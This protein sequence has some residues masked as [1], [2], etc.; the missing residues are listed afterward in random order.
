MPNLLW[1]YIL[2]HNP[3]TFPRGRCPFRTTSEPRRWVLEYHKIPDRNPPVFDYHFVAH[4]H[5]PFLGLSLRLPLLFAVWCEIA[6]R[7]RNC[8]FVKECLDQG[9]YWAK[10]PGHGV[11][12]GCSV[13][14]YGGCEEL[15][16]VF[17]LR[18]GN[19]AFSRSMLELR[20]PSPSVCSLPM[21]WLSRSSDALS[22]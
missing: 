14:E 21:Q 20:V 16:P 8:G 19:Y 7:E 15:R 3:S 13:E 17:L 11:V 4:P 18:L 1:T 9:V 12:G 2:H 6:Q 22:A 10:K 5:A